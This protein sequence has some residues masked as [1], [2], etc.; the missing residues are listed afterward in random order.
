MRRKS[1]SYLLVT[2]QFASLAVFPLTGT[3]LARSPWL[4]AVELA[5][6]FFG[7]WAVLA[8]RLRNLHVLPD[9]RPGA[10]F[11]RRGPYRWI[12]HPM[13]AA[14]LLVSGALT[15]DQP[16]ALRAAA[17]AILLVD[18]LAKLHYEEGLLT[19]AFPEYAQYRQ[20]TKRLVP[21]I[22]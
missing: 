5:G 16:S 7:V 21:F 19:E 10:R 22:Y 13:Y 17:L 2:I 20:Q 9:V 6:L 4:L 11:V 14:L 15:L 12:R 8:V 3:W 18:I 1:L